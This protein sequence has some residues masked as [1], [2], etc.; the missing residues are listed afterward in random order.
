MHILC[1]HFYFLCLKFI[2]AIAFC[3]RLCHDLE[4]CFKVTVQI[5]SIDIIEEQYLVQN[6]IHRFI[7]C[8]YISV[9]S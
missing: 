3:H 9:I 4:L 8:D 6:V 5:M 1:P 2:S 7:T